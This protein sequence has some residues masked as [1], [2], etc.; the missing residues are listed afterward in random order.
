M[1]LRLLNILERE[2]AINDIYGD[3]KSLRKESE[4]TMYI[5]DPFNKEASRSVFNLALNLFEIFV[6]NKELQLLFNH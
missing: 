4:L 6:I 2:E 5:D 1:E 3:I